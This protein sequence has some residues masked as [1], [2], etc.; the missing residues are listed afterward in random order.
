MKMQQES[1]QAK[2]K[3]GLKEKQFFYPTTFE[4]LEAILRHNFNA[5]ANLDNEDHGRQQ[6]VKFY[7][8][9]TLANEAYRG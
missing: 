2:W 5:V 8:D 6:E 9:S 3:T 1:L 7:A 4:N